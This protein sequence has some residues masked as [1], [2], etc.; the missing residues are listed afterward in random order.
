MFLIPFRFRYGVGV[1]GKTD[2]VP[3]LFYIAT[4]YMH[5]GGIPLIPCGSALVYENSRYVENARSSGSDTYVFKTI[6]FSMKGF[7]IGLVRALLFVTFTISLICALF[8]GVMESGLLPTNPAAANSHVAD[9]AYLVVFSTLAAVSGVLLYLSYG[10]AI[11]R[12]RRAV[13]LGEMAGV[14]EDLVL[15]R[16]AFKGYPLLKPRKQLRFHKCPTCTRINII[17]LDAPAAQRVFCTGCGAQ[18]P[19]AP[20][21]KTN[22]VLPILAG[23]AATAVVVYFAVFQQPK[24]ALDASQA[25]SAPQQATNQAGAARP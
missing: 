13:E 2:I 3:G 17:R 25:A 7:L 4:K 20:Q 6:R 18:I 5:V 9:Q 24:K 14:P 1:Y 10:Y 21:K 11:A 23:A 8:L 12:R 15:K 16:L 22:F 19:P